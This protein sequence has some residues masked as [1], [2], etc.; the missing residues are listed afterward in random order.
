M[1]ENKISEKTCTTCLSVKSTKEFYRKGTGFE[2]TCKECKKNKRRATYVS[3]KSTDDFDRIMRLFN[4]V[5]DLEESDLAKLESD[6]DRL[7][8]SHSYNQVA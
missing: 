8:I 6:I 1:S 4:L 7:L 3:K 2:N 5:L